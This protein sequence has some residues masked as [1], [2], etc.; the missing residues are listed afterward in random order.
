VKLF[1]FFVG[2]TYSPRTGICPLQVSGQS[3][4]CCLNKKIETVTHKTVCE[5]TSGY[6]CIAATVSKTQIVDLKKTTNLTKLNYDTQKCDGDILKSIDTEEDI[7]DIRGFGQVLAI[8]P[9]GSLCAG[10]IEVCCK[11]KPTK[12]GG[13]KLEPKKELEY[14]PKCGRHNPEG[15]DIL[16]TKPQDKHTATQFGEWPHACILYKVDSK[17]DDLFIG[18]A[19]LIAPGVVITAAHKVE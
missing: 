6:K 11:L 7:L 9:E 4:I 14:V 8:N 15:I 10:D 17:K 2:G 3:Q 1:H 16:V 12:P 5:E 19:S 13:T 18:G